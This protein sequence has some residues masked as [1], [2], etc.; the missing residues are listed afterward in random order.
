MFFKWLF[1][2]PL[3]DYGCILAAFILF[4]TS[5]PEYKLCLLI[6]F[7]EFFFCKLASLI[8]LT[9]TDMWRQWQIYAVYGA[10]QLCAVLGLFI[11]QWHKNKASIMI[12]L[13]IA[14]AG[15]INVELALSWL[16]QGLT[17]FTAMEIYKSYTNLFGFI[18]F[19]QLLFML[20]CNKQILRQ[21]NKNGRSHSRFIDVAFLVYPRVNLRRDSNEALV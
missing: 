14:S 18:M 3:F 5:K 13:L 16:N 11:A 2:H 21:D 6:L 8:G 12:T 20:L 10:I 1:N 15:L 19:M 9:W 17:S 7:L 4:W